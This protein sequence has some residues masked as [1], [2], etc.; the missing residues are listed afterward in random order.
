MELGNFIVK[1]TSQ[2][3]NSGIKQM[4]T[5]IKNVTG[6]A[7]AGA[8]AITGAFIKMVD[9]TVKQGEELDKLRKITGVSTVELSRLKY[10]AEQEHTSIESLSAGFK[11]LSNIMQQ[12]IDGNKDAISLF[13]EL[14]IEIQNNDGSMRSQVAVMKDVA[15]AFSNIQDETYKSAVAQD[16]FGRSGMDMIPFLNMGK[17][18]IE[19]LG[20]EA[21]KLGIVMGDKTVTDLENFGDSI[22]TIKLAING[23]VISIV[24]DF[25]PTLQNIV[26]E[27]KN[28]ITE[29]DNWKRVISTFITISLE[30]F[31]ILALLLKT[32]GTYLGDLAFFWKMAL[33]PSTTIAQTVDA[34]KILFSDLKT[35]MIDL[36]TTSIDAWNKIKDTA[37]GVQKNISDGNKNIPPVVTTENVKDSKNNM[38]AIEKEWR[39]VVAKMI[40]DGIDWGTET[41][42]LIGGITGSFKDF[43]K[44]IVDN[45]KTA[46]EKFTDFIVSIGDAM[47]D[48]I[49]S[50]AAQAV[51]LSL[52]NLIP[53]MSTFLSGLDRMSR[54]LPKLA[55]G[56]IAT[57]PQ[58][59]MVGEAG[60]EAIIPLNKLSSVTGGNISI[61]INGSVDKDNID[62]I[63][64]K[65][66]KAVRNGQADGLS[67][68]L[69][70][71]GSRL[72]GEV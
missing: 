27:V 54:G 25:L 18:G 52:L 20:K 69:N 66:E 68:A 4:A 64:N 72:S 21:D 53:G 3:D 17:K 37:S 65:L 62:M 41:S 11:K 47:I 45:S 6:L 44:S 28:N 19:E 71:R 22:N 43:F 12:A 42:N 26:A 10:A 24:T 23:I 8:T 39:N 32:V 56:G 49:A 70:T 61:N 57:S 51:V 5:G 60:G 33:D 14:N 36:A 15:T 59:A 16:L 35:G 9:S 29:S 40:K 2:F 38:S 50:I 46:G 13:K 30:G 34:F 7:L 67:K 48:F 31:K 58:L 1:L 55:Y 63:A